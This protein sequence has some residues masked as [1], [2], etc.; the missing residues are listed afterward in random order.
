MRFRDF[1]FF[2]SSTFIYKPILIKIYMN[3]IGWSGDASPSKLC[4]SFSLSIFLLLSISFSLP[5]SFSYSLSISLSI[6]LFCSMQTFIYTQRNVFH[7]MKYDLK[8]HMRCDFKKFSDLLI[9]LQ[10]YFRIIL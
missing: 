2:L 3:S 7:K 9:K 10:S 8:D 6:S 4:V 5:L 1:S